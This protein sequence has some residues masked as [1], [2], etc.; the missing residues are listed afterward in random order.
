MADL[1]GRNKSFLVNDS[2]YILGAILS[3]SAPNLV[4]LIVGR[5]LSG[6]AIGTGSIL[7]P[8]ILTEI[9]WTEI[10]GSIGVLNQL[11]VTV[12]ILLAFVVNSLFANVSD[13]LNWR[14]EFGMTCFPPFVHLV[15]ALILK[16]ESPRWLL[17]KGDLEGAK[18]MLRKL[19]SK[20]N[21]NQDI[22]T[23]AA[24]EH[25]KTPGRKSK[26]CTKRNAKPLFIGI[27]IN[28]FQQAV[29]VNAIM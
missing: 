20:D 22:E 6:L 9:S 14:I 26:L 11:F 27:A 29:G 8:L 1:I 28:F 21:V 18:Q 16:V 17:M 12:G 19:R 2:L 23:L 25:E 3:A 10:R 5:V 24:E 4:V 13:N 15:L 7:V